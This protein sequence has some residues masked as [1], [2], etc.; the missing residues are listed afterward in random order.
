MKAPN[1]VPL[2]KVVFTTASEHILARCHKAI[3]VLIGRKRRGIKAP[4]EFA[5]A[6]RVQKVRRIRAWFTLKAI[7][8]S[9]GGKNFKL[10]ILP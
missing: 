6:V 2:R 7:K 4:D 8:T 3:R 5:L 10:T 9:I 1:G